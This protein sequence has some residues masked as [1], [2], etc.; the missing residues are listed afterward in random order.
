MSGR[1]DTKITTSHQGEGVQPPPPSPSISLS[2]IHSHLLVISISIIGNIVRILDIIIES[3]YIMF[4]I[5]D[6]VMSE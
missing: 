6:L 2:H 1:G 4:S 5:F 3:I